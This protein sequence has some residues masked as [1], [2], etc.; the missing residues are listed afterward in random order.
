MDI[1]L[2]NSIQLLPDGE[3]PSST[4]T[5]TKVSRSV[6]DGVT[7]EPP[8]FLWY[9]TGKNGRDLTAQEKQDDLITELDVLYGVDMPWYGFEKI[10]P[11][12]TVEAPG[13]VTVESEWITYRK[14]IKSE[15]VVA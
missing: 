12:I 13:R 8:L 15:F 7:G 1:P 14:G 6:R 4:E 5:W 11:S 3:L 10:Q 9:R 2:I